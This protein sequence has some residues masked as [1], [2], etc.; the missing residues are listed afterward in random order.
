MEALITGTL[1]RH[2]ESGL[3][4]RT[5]DREVP[6]EWPFG[7]TAREQP[8]GVELLDES[9]TVVAREGDEVALA[10]GAVG[11]DGAGFWRTCGEITEPRGFNEVQR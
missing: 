4:L 10:G 1:V 8:G 3:V 9:G 6:V 11:R 7:Y 2:P 5:R